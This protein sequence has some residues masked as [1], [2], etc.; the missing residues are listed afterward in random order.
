M[1]LS[2]RVHDLHKQINGIILNVLLNVKKWVF[3]FMAKVIDLS[4]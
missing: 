2:K 1:E 4:L 3:H